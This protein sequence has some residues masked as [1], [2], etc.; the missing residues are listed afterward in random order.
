MP[1]T[2]MFRDRVVS[3]EQTFEKGEKH[4]SLLKAIVDEAIPGLEFSEYLLDHEHDRFVMIYRSPSGATKR[5][6]WTRMVLSD[7]ERIPAIVENAQA[8]IRGRL[9]EFLRK[10]GERNSIDVT[11]RHL[12]EGWVDT[13]EPQKAR[14]Q[15]RE[16]AKASSPPQAGASTR[17]RGGPGRPPPPAPRPAPPGPRAP[18]PPAP[19]EGGPRPGAASPA[20]PAGPGRRRRF[21]RRRGRRRGGPGSGPVSPPTSGGAAPA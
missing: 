21:R 6:A 19:S 2:K 8:E 9:V 12:E 13:P 18:R 10:C 16:K 20:A 14:P 7:A 11:F 15:P 1:S 3:M 4:L 17:P 5:I